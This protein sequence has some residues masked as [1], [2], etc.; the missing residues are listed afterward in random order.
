MLYKE[1]EKGDFLMYILLK[2][3]NPILGKIL[4]YLKRSRVWY[5]LFEEK[6]YNAIVTSEDR[7]ATKHQLNRGQINPKRAWETCQSFR[8]IWDWDSMGRGPWVSGK[9]KAPTGKGYVIDRFGN[10]CRV[11]GDC[12]N[13]QMLNYISCPDWCPNYQPT[14]IEGLI[15]LSDQARNEH[16]RRAESLSRQTDFLKQTE[17]SYEEAIKTGKIIEYVDGR[18][19]M[20][21]T[22]E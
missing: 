20:I 2:V 5:R 16:I 15:Y 8:E 10:K 11:A 3:D 18:F 13:P 21:E 22:T 7:I 14:T 9:G 4:S 12:V 1:L 6:M 19:I 17:L